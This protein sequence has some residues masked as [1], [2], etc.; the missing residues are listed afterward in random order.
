MIHAF[1]TDIAE[2]HGVAAAIVHQEILRWCKFNEVEKTEEV[3]ID[4]YYW[5]Y[6]SHN[7]L[8]NHFPY[9]SVST[10]RR[11]LEK[12]VEND[13]LEKRNRVGGNPNALIYRALKGV[14]EKV[15][16]PMVKMNI[17][18]G[19]NEHTPYGQNEQSEHRNKEHRK[20]T[21]KPMSKKP[22]VTLQIESLNGQLQHNGLDGL[23]ALEYFVDR[24]KARELELRPR[25]INLTDEKKWAVKRQSWIRDTIAVMVAQNVT[26]DNLVKLHGRVLKD[27]GDPKSGFAYRDVIRSP[28]KYNEK[29]SNGCVFFD[30]MANKY[31]GKK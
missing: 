12:L 26:L 15:D 18:Y 28:G 24:F 16:T 25:N 22:D 21:I 20:E 11:A 2:R 4:G 6:T 7:R 3:F 8:H 10:I 31:W 17:P 23:E 9:L 19:Q 14:Y 29:M 5:F 13:L 30:E 1:D 27:E